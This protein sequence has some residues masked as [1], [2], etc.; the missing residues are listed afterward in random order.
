MIGF[1]FSWICGDL[2]FL[3]QL[4]VSPERQGHSIGRELLKRALEHAQSRAAATKALITFAF[5]RVSQ[6]LYIRHGLFPQTPLY[7]VN[8]ARDDVMNRLPAAQL[9]HVR[10]QDTVSALHD[11]ARIDLDVLGVSRQK[12]HRHLMT[13]GAMKGILLYKGDD[14]VA[15]AYVSSG[16]QI[17]PLAVAWPDALEDAFTTALKL[18]AEGGAARVSAFIPGANETALRIALGLGMQITFPMLLMS[19]RS[20][21]DWARYLPRN[22]GFM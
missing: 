19:T 20:F 21:G 5:N 7:G 16:G 1:A 22:P 17:G 4:F 3:A 15:Y 18:A 12:H 9:R 10:L 14:P 6:G 11:L 13:N 2:W 8:I